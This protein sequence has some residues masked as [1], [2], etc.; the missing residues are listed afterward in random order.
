MF[1]KIQL[2]AIEQFY[3]SAL[4]WDFLQ[5]IRD[6]WAITTLFRPTYVTLQVFQ[7]FLGHTQGFNERLKS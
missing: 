2:K 6:F 1:I 3:I 7:S 5:Y 4:H